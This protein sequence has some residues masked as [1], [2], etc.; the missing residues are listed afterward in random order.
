MISEV[1]RVNTRGATMSELQEFDWHHLPRPIYP[2]DDL[3]DWQ[4]R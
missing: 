4:A 1:I 3:P 2:F